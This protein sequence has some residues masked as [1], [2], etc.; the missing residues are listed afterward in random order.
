L[1]RL[2]RRFAPKPI[3]SLYHFFLAFL[4]AVRYGFPSKKLIVV[5][6]T[7]TKGKTTVTELIN[8][9]LEVAGYKTAVLNSARFKI[10]DAKQPNT[11]GT[12]MPGRFFIQ[13][14]LRDAA[15]QRCRYA[16]IEVTSQGIIQH[17][18]R[19]IDFDSAILTNL[20]PEHIEA[21][22]SFEKYRRSKLKLFRSLMKSRKPR[23]VA[24]LN[25]DDKNFLYFRERLKLRE[26]LLFTA[27]AV[28]EYQEKADEMQFVFD[29]LRITMNSFGQCNLENALAA[30]AF[31]RSRDIPMGIICDGL[32]KFSGV[33]GRFEF[34]QRSPFAVI[35]D[36][37]HT[38]DSLSAIY[39]AVKR[40]QENGNLNLI[41]NFH[42]PGTRFLCV[43]GA[44]GGGRD[45]W[46]RPLMG[47]IASDF[48]DE[49]MLTTEDP[50]DEDPEK[51]IKDI[52][53]GVNPAVSGVL[54]V[55]EVVDR[56][57]AIAMAIRHARPGDAVI[58]TGK[59]SEPWMFLA[60]GQKIPWSDKETA[61][62]AIDKQEM[63]S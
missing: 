7:G 19:F 47:K 51:I 29:R 39:A 63:N 30:I 52:R 45:A 11:T 31:A 42:E 34:V 22:G 17:R 24:I 48:C 37:A 15:D 60:K 35:V 62:G 14:F 56:K 43:L 61:R 59:G 40:L 25:G 32:T 10:G 33:P 5:G 41:T 38:P 9:I 21:H 46:K 3:V 26:V 18:H 8:T 28:K 58:I 57:K 16:I 49:I 27:K 13:K 4:G 2:L 54:D 50:H 55:Y 1:I 6:V 36:Y 20:A 53:T 44:S 23:R 12:T